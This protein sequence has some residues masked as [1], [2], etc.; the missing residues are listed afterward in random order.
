[1]IVCRPGPV[2][3]VCQRKSIPFQPSTGP[4]HAI[5]C[6]RSGVII[7]FSVLDFLR[8]QPTG[9]GHGLYIGRS[10]IRFRCGNN[11][12]HRRHHHRNRNLDGDPR[13]RSKI[14]NLG[15]IAGNN[16]AKWK[17]PRGADNPRS[18]IKVW[19]V[20]RKIRP[21]L[22]QHNDHQTV[23]AKSHPAARRTPTELAERTTHFGS[24]L[25]YRH[26]R[27]SIAGAT[28]RRSYLFPSKIVVRNGRCLRRAAAGASAL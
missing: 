9:N 28:K 10:R 15:R 16:F 18:L 23:G 27:I 14:Q 2:V 7:G 12:A 25:P 24:R 26:N 8:G 17:E 13:Q 6:G 3:P 22:I 20:R 4:P 11:S 19:G 5:I 21:A 1:M